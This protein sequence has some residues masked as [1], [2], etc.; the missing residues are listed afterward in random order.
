M[1][2]LITLSQGLSLMTTRSIRLVAYLVALLALG[3]GVSRPGTLHPAWIPA[4]AGRSGI[5]LN[6]MGLCRSSEAAPCEG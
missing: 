2:C 5:E 3:T 1:I 4:F 6:L